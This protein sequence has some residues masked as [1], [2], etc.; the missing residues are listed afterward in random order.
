MVL[1]KRKSANALSGEMPW[2]SPL[3]WGLIWIRRQTVQQRENDTSEIKKG[4]HGMKHGL[5][6]AVHPVQVTVS[7][8]GKGCTGTW[9]F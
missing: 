4:I 7:C 3:F 9:C 5:A 8:A 1:A 2:N 6:K